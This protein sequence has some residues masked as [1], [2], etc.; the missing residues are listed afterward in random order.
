[1]LHQGIAVGCGLTI[2]TLPAGVHPKLRIP[3]SEQQVAWEFEVAP[4]ADEGIIEI[5]Q[6]RDKDQHFRLLAWLKNNPGMF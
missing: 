5:S 4:S 6:E 3:C 1:M 2:F